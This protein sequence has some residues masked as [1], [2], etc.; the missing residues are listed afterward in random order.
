MKEFDD[1]LCGNVLGIGIQSVLPMTP[2]SGSR[3]RRSTDAFDVLS[4]LQCH[5]KN[6]AASVCSVSPRSTEVS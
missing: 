5:A 4:Q 1:F 6:L 3:F 2:T